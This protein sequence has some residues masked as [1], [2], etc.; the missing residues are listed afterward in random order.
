VFILPKGTSRVIL[1]KL[2][3]GTTLA[4]REPEIKYRRRLAA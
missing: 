1:W 2:E 3:V 4:S